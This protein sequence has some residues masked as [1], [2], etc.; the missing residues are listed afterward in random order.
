ML[1]LSEARRNF[2]ILILVRFPKISLHKD[3]RI[4]RDFGFFVLFEFV[5]IG[6]VGHQ[7]VYTCDCIFILLGLY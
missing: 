4:F 6:V 5:R 7:T 1:T 3:F 2:D